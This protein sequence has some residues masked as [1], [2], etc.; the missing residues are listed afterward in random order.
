MF[1]ILIVL[2]ISAGLGFGFAD[3]NFRIGS[4][5][6]AVLLSRESSLKGQSLTIGDGSV[7]GNIGEEYATPSQSWNVS[8]SWVVAFG[9]E[10]TACEDVYLADRCSKFRGPTS[11]FADTRKEWQSARCRCN[12]GCDMTITRSSCGRAYLEPV[13]GCDVPYIE[14]EG[15][16]PIFPEVGKDKIGSFLVRPGC[17]I[18]LYEEEDFEEDAETIEEPITQ[19]WSGTIGSYECRCSDADQLRQRNYNHPGLLAA[20]SSLTH[21]RSSRNA[22]ILLI[23]SS[24]A[25]KSSAINILLNN[26]NVTL[27]GEDKSTTSEILEFRIPIPVPELG[28]QNSELRIIDTPGLGDTR[29]LENDAIFLATLDNYLSEHSDLKTK[30]P[31]LVLVFHHFTDNRYNGE[32]AKFVNMIRGLDSFRTRITDENYSNVLFVFTH[33]CSETS[34]TLLQNPSIKLM[35][36]KEVIEEYSLFPK[37]ILTSV[38][39][40]KG[41]E[42]ELLMVNDNYILPNNE[43]FP[44]NLINK[45]DTITMKGNDTM[46]RAIIFSAFRKRREYPTIHESRFDLVSSN[47]PKVAKYLN[48]LSA[49]ILHIESTE[50]SQQLANAFNSMS[51]QLKTQFPTSLN[52]LQKYLSVRN[53]RTKADLPKTTI[54]IL[55]LLEEIEKNEAVLFML[56][57]GLNLKA[58]TFP[59]SILTS[60]SFSS[61]KD[62]VLPLS[63]Y[64]LDTLKIS[65]MGYKLSDA[66]TCEK[67]SATF[68]LLSAFDTKEKYVC[69]RARSFGVNISIAGNFEIYTGLQNKVKEGFFIK[70]TQCSNNIC[71]FVASRLY[72][73]FQFDLEERASL[74]PSFIQRVNNL[75]AFN[76]ASYESID[77]WTKFFNDYGTH[78]VKSALVGGRIDINVRSPSSISV[79]S[80]KDKL[81]QT[82][83]FAENINSLITGEKIDPKGLL[84]SRVTY[85]LVFHGGSPSYHTSN[86]TGLN[87]EEAVKNMKNWKKSL[88]FDP[89]VMPTEIISIERVA[90]AIGSEKADYIREASLRLQNSSLSYVAP[91][92]D[93]KVLEELARKQKENE[94]KLKQLAAEKKRKEEQAERERLAAIEAQRQRE[95]ERKLLEEQRR[96]DKRR[97]E[98]ELARK[99]EEE[100]QRYL[101]Q[102]EEE[103][104]RA[105]EYRRRMERERWERIREIERLEREARWRAEREW[106]EQQRRRRSSCLK[107]GTKILLADFTEKS[108]EN[109]E[110]GDILL[111]KELKPTRVVGV[112]YEFLL[113]QKF[114][115]FDNQSFFFTDTHLFMGPSE[116]SN[117]QLYTTSKKDLFAQNPLLEYLNVNEFKEGKNTTLFYF[118]ASIENQP[119]VKNVQVFPEPKIYPEETPIYF[120]QVDSPSGTYFAEG[121]VCRHE[122]PPLEFWPNT[123]AALFPLFESKGFEKVSELPYSEL[124]NRGSKMDR[125]LAVQVSVQ[126]RDR[127]REPK[128]FMKEP[129][130]GTENRNS[131]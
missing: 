74:S 100:R 123:M 109:L 81:F 112:S 118:D 12:T 105:E 84:P 36:F 11:P 17:T 93:P 131:L 75:G 63:P 55:E 26:H 56:D 65:K 121:F 39:E 35:K 45:F 1:F 31:N 2:F 124:V 62:E 19:N 87:L 33:F 114:Y 89:V 101:R 90:Q 85:S 69:Y 66:I 72:K 111:D 30:I 24:G 58:P 83:E 71:T 41:K 23:G 68:N 60:F 120:I 76:E 126:N 53:I 129:K 104:R 15:S 125:G 103:E 7:L 95:L 37:P 115:G 21:G 54:K 32:G 117:G 102:K 8:S 79:E 97:E 119:I 59:K 6:C 27:A 52:Y 44:S 82:V 98:R 106:E 38:I 110:I 14:L 77:K 51:S 48:I 64:K 127:D 57:N 122:I 50:I 5:T 25:G 99:L 88:K 80:F 4:K 22:Y 86:L 20:F 130:T 29:G 92:P 16:N 49:S 47:H 116:N 113:T 91:T 13:A 128:Y 9:C 43:Y 3:S 94:E 67:K 10:L 61:M 34:K 28:V 40:N 70:D 18:N 73:L 42:N 78:V 46:G 108:V 107:E 96:E